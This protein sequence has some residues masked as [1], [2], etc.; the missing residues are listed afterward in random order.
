LSLSRLFFSYNFLCQRDSANLFSLL[1]YCRALF[2]LPIPTPPLFFF[3][4]FS[5]QFFP[6]E[7]SFFFFITRNPSPG[8]LSRTAY[9]PVVSRNIKYVGPSSQALPAS[10]SQ[11]WMDYKGPPPFGIQ[12]SSLAKYTPPLYPKPVR[13]ELFFYC[14]I[15][16][17]LLLVV[18]ARTSVLFPSL[19]TMRT[20]FSFFS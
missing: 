6:A 3:P 11:R 17:S 19:L 12:V 15:S 2:S 8:I 1:I 9:S 18:S 7:P 10:F 14:D 16:L 5:Q 4:L 13:K 20:F